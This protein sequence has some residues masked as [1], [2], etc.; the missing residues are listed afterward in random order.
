MKTFL[1]LATEACVAVN[2]VKN[3]GSPFKLFSSLKHEGY[4]VTGSGIRLKLIIE[5]PELH[6]F[7]TFNAVD[8]HGK[9]NILLNEKPSISEPAVM[10]CPVFVNVLVT[11]EQGTNEETRDH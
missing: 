4:L 2:F 9:T 8:P 11:A 6:S 3:M 1:M 10:G 7:V 5:R